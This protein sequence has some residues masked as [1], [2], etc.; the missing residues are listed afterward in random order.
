MAWAEPAT[1][2]EP[3]MRSFIPKQSSK[4]HGHFVLEGISFWWWSLF[5]KDLQS[6]HKAGH[7]PWE[8]WHKNIWRLTLPFFHGHQQQSPNHNSWASRWLRF[9][10]QPREQDR[11]CSQR[12]TQTPAR[13]EPLLN[14]SCEAEQCTTKES[15][16]T[17][18]LMSTWGSHRELTLLCAEV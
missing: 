1:S 16:K 14:P 3:R 18:V 12:V 2:K 6:D 8:P 4:R 11:S 10:K 7:I 17:D 9:W 13:E 5:G 15:S